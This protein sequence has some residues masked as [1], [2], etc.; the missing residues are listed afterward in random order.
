MTKELHDLRTKALNCHILYTPLVRSVRY[1]FCTSS[2]ASYCRDSCIFQQPT[3]CRKVLAA[4]GIPQLASDVLST[5]IMGKRSP[6]PQ[7]LDMTIHPSRPAQSEVPATTSYVVTMKSSHLCD[8]IINKKASKA[9]K[10]RCPI[11]SLPPEYISG[12]RYRQ[13]EHCARRCS[14]WKTTIILT[15]GCHF[16]R[17]LLK[18]MLQPVTNRMHSSFSTYIA[19]NL[20]GDVRYPLSNDPSRS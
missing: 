18:P 8:F 3:G 20:F 9:S 15:H 4:L 12:T 14:N 19:I 13:C 1:A 6:E 7:N 16:N 10:L 5:R 2:R 11:L 17:N